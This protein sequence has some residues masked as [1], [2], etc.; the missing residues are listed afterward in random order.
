[1]KKW[2]SIFIAV[3]LGLLLATSSIIG[4]NIAGKAN[5]G[6][7]NDEDGFLSQVVWCDG[8]DYVIYKNTDQKKFQVVHTKQDLYQ[9]ET[10]GTVHSGRV[11]YLYSFVNEGEKNFGIEPVSK[12]KDEQW[13]VPLLKAE[14]TFLAAG[15]TEKEILVSILENDGRKVT[16]YALSLGTETKEWRETTVFSLT[17]GHFAVCGAYDGEKL[18]LAQE[19]GTVYIRDVVVTELGVAPQD[20]IL[21]NYFTK[22]ILSGAEGIWQIKCS[23]NAAMQC[24]I[25]VLLVSAFGVLFFY[26]RRK[27]NHMIYHLI[28]YSEII[29]VI[30]LIAAG[31]IF[32]DRLT[33]QEVM[34]TGVEAGYV[35]EELK[36][37]QRADGTVEA[38]D[39]WK[40]AKQYEDLMDD[41][42]ILNPENCEVIQAKTLTTGMNVLEFYENK[43]EKL[44]QQTAEGNKTA[45]MQLS[46]GAGSYAVAS[47]DFTQIE[48]KSLLLAMISRAGIEKRIEAAVSAIWNVILLLMAAVTILHMVLFLLFT[49]KWKKFLE[50]MEFVAYEKQAY[51]DRPVTE[52]GLHSAWAPLDRIGHNIVKLRYER[53]LLY[54]SYYRFVPK[55]MDQLLKKPEMADI[56]I[57]DNN[58]INGCMVHFQMENIKN[59]SGSDYMDVMTESL[60][61]MH[62]I[63]EKHE[64][65]FISA[66]G[67]LQNRKVFFEQSPRQALAFAVEMYRAHATKETLMN[68]NIIMMLHQADYNYGI[69]GV[70]DMMS[71]FIYCPDEKILDAYVDALARAKVRIVL[72]E[73]TLASV[74]NGYSVR[75]IGFVSGGEMAGSMK[76]YECLDAY[77]EEKRKVMIESDAYFQKAL[78]LFYSNDFYLARNA[79]NEV[80]KMNE[81]DEIARWYLFHC[82]YHLNKPEAEV[83]YGL[84][85]KQF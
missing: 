47:R 6:K 22:N 83:S 56:E 15:S 13:N 37:G 82:E 59:V 38:S 64:G 26:G 72:T 40:V 58:K 57:G 39:Y 60:K 4:I 20:S 84:F 65:V 2:I 19:D 77:T 8:K 44:I 5:H 36:A 25:P 31:Y 3:S 23:Q 52:D 42:I 85:E 32:T 79:F 62:Q 9:Y 67:D 33:K 46:K 61:Q 54:R 27:Q 74:G 24:L 49:S 76:L 12:K 68:T 41:I 1:M 53:D 35:L 34:E 69:S 30:G 10:V 50:G 16:E 81:Q 55:G 21:A 51:V 78:K 18:I 28:S 45:M 66:G 63:R 14:G 80:L 73:Q 71:P 43:I 48:A 17:E 11:Y 70:D 75:Y 7:V 29:C